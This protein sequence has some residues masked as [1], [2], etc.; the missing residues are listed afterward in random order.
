[1][2]IEKMTWIVNNSNSWTMWTKILGWGPMTCDI[3]I[4][5]GS[6]PDKNTTTPNAGVPNHTSASH[7]DI[8]HVTFSV[9]LFGVSW[10]WTSRLLLSLFLGLNNISTRDLD[11]LKYTASRIL[12][13]GRL[14][15]LLT[16]FT[17]YC[18]ED[19]SKDFTILTFW[20]RWITPLKSKHILTLRYYPVHD[21]GGILETVYSFHV[22]H[23][24][25]LV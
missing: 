3:W 24:F 16:H 18:Q 17:F 6:G 8:H 25:E 22:R 13:I 23:T 21:D 11:E 4:N 12:R 19:I 20:T 2:I 5:S 10:S 14:L 1:M 15:N 7:S 9:A